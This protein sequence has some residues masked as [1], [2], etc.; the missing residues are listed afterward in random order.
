M[1]QEALYAAEMQKVRLLNRTYYPP[2][3]LCPPIDGDG[4]KRREGLHP[5]Q[6]VRP[7]AAHLPP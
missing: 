7:K 2:S 6:K 4:A 5:A 1:L 3:E